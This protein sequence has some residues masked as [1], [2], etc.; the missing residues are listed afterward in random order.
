MTFPAFY[1][2]KDLK[3]NTFAMSRQFGYALEETLARYARPVG[4]QADIT[5]ME[6]DGVDVSHAV[7]V[8]VF[9]EEGTPV[10]PKLRGKKTGFVIKFVEKW[11]ADKWNKKGRTAIYYWKGNKAK[12]PQTVAEAL[13]M[14]VEK[15]KSQ[16]YGMDSRGPGSEYHD[17]EQKSLWCSNYELYGHHQD[18]TMKAT[19]FPSREAAQTHL[20]IMLENAALYQDKYEPRYTNDDESMKSEKE[21][22]KITITEVK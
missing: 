9:L 21:R 13:A 4:A 14:R 12:K 6:S 20:D 2:I 19:V 22:T 18:T 8:P 10:K 17:E 1:V 7:I 15:R 5:V 11:P 16:G 3:T